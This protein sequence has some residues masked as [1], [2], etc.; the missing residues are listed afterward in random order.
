MGISDPVV[1]VSDMK[2]ILGYGVMSVPALVIDGIVKFNGRVP[3]KEEIKKY[4][5]GEPGSSASDCGYNGGCR[6]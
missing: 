2:E 6:C 5:Q 1:K 3:S 4:L